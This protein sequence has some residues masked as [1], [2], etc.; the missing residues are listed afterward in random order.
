MSTIKK[1]IKQII[2]ILT[3]PIVHTWFWYHRWIM[4]NNFLVWLK[5]KEV[6]KASLIYYPFKIVNRLI[7]FIII[8]WQ[9]EFIDYSL[10]R[11]KEL[12]DFHY[13][14]EGIGY[15]DFHSKSKKELL[16]I[17]KSISGR[18]SYFIKNNYLTSIYKDGDSFL[19]VGCGKGQ[20][21]KEIVYNYPSSN[22]KGFDINEGVL[23]IVKLA[24]KGYSNVN[25]EQGS[26]TDFDYL[27]T[28]ANNSVD[29]I[30]FC[31][32]LS[33]ITGTDVESTRKIRQTLIDHLIRIASK[34]VIILENRSIIYDDDFIDYK[35]EQNTRGTF[36]E[37]LLPY[38]TN[39]INDKANLC[40]MFSPET[41]ALLFKKG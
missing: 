32:A 40:A 15:L 25:V 26:V 21:I 7:Q 27:A 20:N 4:H 11:Y 37:S 35:I 31:H 2:I 39:H 1:H 30:I 38:F 6:G 34:S 12:V 28:Y 13:S 5:N 41:T 19:D 8:I 33:F 36:R 9:K 18:I 22:I 23:K 16:N 29:H 17:Y 3:K 24:L 10:K 14:T